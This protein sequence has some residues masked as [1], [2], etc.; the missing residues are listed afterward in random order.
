MTFDYEFVNFSTK[1]FF[2]NF[3]ETQA[4]SPMKEIVRLITDRVS[5]K[6]NAIGRVRPSDVR[7]FVFT[8]TQFFLLCIMVYDVPDF[9]AE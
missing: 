9:T 8:L 2:L 4:Q 5:G 7:P 1:V 6:G 3:S